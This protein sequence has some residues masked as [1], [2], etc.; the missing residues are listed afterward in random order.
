[1]DEKGKKQLAHV[2]ISSL[3]ADVAYF[4]ARLTLLN[5]EIGS[6]YQRA[7]IQ[8]YRGLKE[9]LSEMLEKLRGLPRKNGS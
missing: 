3:E 6:S 4:D 2:S 8:A 5:G 1:M 7:Q 9:V